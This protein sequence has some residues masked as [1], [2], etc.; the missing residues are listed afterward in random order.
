M[1]RIILLITFLIIFSCATNKEANDYKQYEFVLINIPVGENSNQMVNELRFTGDTKSGETQ[2]FMQYKYGKQIN[3]IPT[4]RALPMQIWTNVK[5]F[6]WTEEL[7]TVGI[8]GDYIKNPTIEID[9]KQKYAIIEYNSVIAFDS[10]NNDCFKTNHHL[11]DSL[12]NYFILNTR[13]TK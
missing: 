10:K 9:G 12:A 2:K 6:N 13:K 11:K 4:N 5:L 7:F 3:E 1:K 8:C